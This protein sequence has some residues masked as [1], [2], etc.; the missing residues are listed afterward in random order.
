MC[1]LKIY[2]VAPKICVPPQTPRCLEPPFIYSLL[3][4]VALDYRIC[5]GNGGA[6]L[7]AS[8]VT[9]PLLAGRHLGLFCSRARTSAAV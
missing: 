4:L 2:L 9:C 5:Q 3:W 7:M 8:V 6:R 1:H